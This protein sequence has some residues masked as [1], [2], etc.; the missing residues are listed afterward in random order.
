MRTC[1][2]R[3][4]AHIAASRIG[5]D[6][7]LPGVVH[8]RLLPFVVFLCVFATSQWQCV[9]VG[10]SMRWRGRSASKV[11]FSEVTLFS[12]GNGAVLL[13]L[14]PSSSCD[15]G[16]PGVF[17]GWGGLPRIL[18]QMVPSAHVRMVSNGPILGA[19]GRVVSFTWWCASWIQCVV[20][21]L[22]SIVWRC[23]GRV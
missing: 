2:P 3:L 11:T 17:V 13:L 15:F 12:V 16:F 10:V 1:K 19:E 4:A 14:S 6:L 9:N 20:S 22:R 23:I 5:A 21:Y 18:V 7:P 8:V